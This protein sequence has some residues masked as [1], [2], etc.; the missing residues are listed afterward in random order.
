MWGEVMN[1][2]DPFGLGPDADTDFLANLME[3]DGE[4]SVR[5]RNVPDPSSF[6]FDA[7]SERDIPPMDR[8]SKRGGPNNPLGINQHTYKHRHSEPK[9]KYGRD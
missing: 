6:G 1:G 5:R 3:R 8:P 4:G 9:Y 7:D 2:F